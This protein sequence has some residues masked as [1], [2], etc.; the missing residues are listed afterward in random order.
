M[1]NDPWHRLNLDPLTATEIDVRR[2][3]AR[4][5]KAQRP[6]ADPEGF[7]K[8]YDA[9]QAAL[10]WL[11]NPPHE[12]GFE[13]LEND[14]VPEE[15][16]AAPQPPQSDSSPGPEL[17]VNSVPPPGDKRPFLTAPGAVPGAVVLPCSDIELPDTHRGP[18][19]ERE[20]ADLA[21]SL[22]KRWW[23]SSR[24]IRR[25]AAAFDAAGL[26]FRFRAQ[27]WYRAA[28]GSIATL[29]RHMP[30]D[31]LVSQ[32]KNDEFSLCRE[33]IS[34]WHDA[35]EWHRMARFS[36][37]LLESMSSHVSPATADFLASLALH[38]SI[39]EPSAAENVANMAYAHIGLDRRGAFEDDVSPMIWLGRQIRELPQRHQR[40]WKD[41]LAYK[42]KQPVPDAPA[43][44]KMIID[45]MDRA[46]A[47]KGFDAAYQRMP[48]QIQTRMD[49]W[50]ITMGKG[51]PVGI[52]HTDEALSPATRSFVKFLLGI[53]VLTILPNLSFYDD[54]PW[55][56]VFVVIVGVVMLVRLFIRL[57]A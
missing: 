52:S 36:Q 33:C 14:L 11:K 54:S 26:S 31:L 27:E 46:P 35:G 45:T 2:A 28:G 38:L 49:R 42:R 16:V 20:I 44:W 4:M 19:Y 12:V 15:S 17:P 39:A 5:L 40:F 13:I 18:I 56:F 57:W 21:R 55:M 25:T 1:M 22:K 3:Y 32:I 29:A 47:W 24:T 9:Y 41:V 7:R 37:V 43:I 53:V 30:D 8:L 50:R 34:H 6:E 10:S 23:P 51:Y 48:P